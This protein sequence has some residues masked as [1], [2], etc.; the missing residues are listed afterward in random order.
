MDN[1]IVVE[2]ES[3][4]EPTITKNDII[5]A[6]TRANKVVDNRFTFTFKG[7]DRAKSLFYFTIYDS[8]L[9]YGT[10]CTNSLEVIDGAENK[11]NLIIMRGRTALFYEY[12]SDLRSNMT[13]DTDSNE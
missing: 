3:D 10:K 1:D 5:D 2:S 4:T 6:V 11:V 13:Q 8:V 12:E 7:I 9:G